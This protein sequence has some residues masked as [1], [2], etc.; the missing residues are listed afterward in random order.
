MKLKVIC[1]ICGKTTTID[2]EKPIKSQPKWDNYKLGDLDI[3]VDKVWHDYDIWICEDCLKEVTE[4][5]TL[6]YDETEY[7]VDREIDYDKLREMLEKSLFSKKG[8]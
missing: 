5:E 7:Y 1:Q 8:E 6:I 2:T 3:E 4:H